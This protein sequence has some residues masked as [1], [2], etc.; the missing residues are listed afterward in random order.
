M[1]FKYLSKQ[2]SNRRYLSADFALHSQINKN[3]V[4]PFAQN[5]HNG[6]MAETY[7]PAASFPFT[8]S[9]VQ[10]LLP[11]AAA[12]IV[13]ASVSPAHAQVARS[14]NNTGFEQNDPG[15]SGAP[16]FEVLPN[17][18]VPG[19]ESTTGEIELWDSNF[20]GVPAASGNV[21]AE[22]N[23]NRP[24]A[25]YQN[26][27]LVN[28]ET[29]RWR[30]AHR[31]RAGGAATQ[32]AVFQIANSSGVAIQTLQTST[33]SNTT[34]WALRSNT[35]GVTYTGPSGVQR[36]QFITTDPGSV[37]NFLD[38]IQIGLGAYI[39]FDPAATSDNEGAASPN[40]TA[41][42][43]T[44]NFA[45]SVNVTVNV[46]G[47]TATLGS[48]YTTPSGTTSFTVTI[49]AGD[50]QSVRIPLG[51]VIIQ[52][53]LIEPSETI[54][55]Q[56]TPDPANFAIASTTTCGGTANTTAVHTIVD[57]DVP[58]V[59]ISDSAIGVNG[60]LGNPAALNVLANDTIN[61][62]SAT[63]SNSIL[64]VAPGSSVP[65]QLLFDPATGVVGV[66]AGSPAG[67]YSFDYQICDA[68][69]PS[70]CRVATVSVTV[71]PSVD[72][73][74]T[75]SNGSNTVVSGQA[76]T[77]VLTVSNAGPDSVTGGLVQ[78]Q[79]VSGLNCVGTG[80][81]S[82]TGSGVPAGSFTISD[83]TGPGI[84]LGTLANGQSANLSYSCEVL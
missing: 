69:N 50:Y 26:I 75:K 76:T 79:P 39:E 19:W 47:G 49:P 41:L 71:D 37:G 82:I 51:L 23:A 21:F 1:R 11:I 38:D 40:V 36:V 84:A 48:D 52:D 22:M 67:N 20:N 12:L 2:M 6:S 4:E 65:T 5:L 62:V 17:T 63:A 25:L 59:A 61:G 13:L 55:L 53:G 42:R 27:C 7:R 81:V 66:I 10:S 46:I 29:I 70:I 35:T 58:P 43:V 34:A 56:I 78:D 33:T 14:M 18:A 3:A 80:P 28:G 68:L 31:A 60:V 74:I 72:L 83:L 24:G 32:T 15:G 9:C 57:D 54:E 30:F 73:V 45:S 16:T 44:G 77:Y 64:S 8:R